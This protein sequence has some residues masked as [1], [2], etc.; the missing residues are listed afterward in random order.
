MDVHTLEFRRVISKLDKKKN[1]MHKIGVWN[2]LFEPL[3]ASHYPRAFSAELVGIKISIVV[4][5]RQEGYDD[6]VESDNNNS[7]ISDINNSLRGR[8]TFLSPIMDVMLSCIK[9]FTSCYFQFIPYNGNFG[10]HII[11]NTFG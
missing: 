2:V 1:T 6:I 3:R 4:V 8:P 5:A 7:A 10:V 11:D 9:T